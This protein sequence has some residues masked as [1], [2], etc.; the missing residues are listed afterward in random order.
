M[1]TVRRLLPSP[2]WP[3]KLAGATAAGGPEGGATGA[4]G[5]MLGR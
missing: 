4:T 2:T 1:T 3:T 5:A